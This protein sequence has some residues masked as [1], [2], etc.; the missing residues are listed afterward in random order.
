[1]QN[2]IELQYIPISEILSSEKNLRYNDKAVEIVM[3]RIREN[4]FLNPIILDGLIQQIQ[5]K[6]L[7]ISL[8]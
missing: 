3:K 1:M 7:I 8:L 2:K 5:Q 4:G 6:S